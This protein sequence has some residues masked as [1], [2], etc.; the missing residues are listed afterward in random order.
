MVKYVI[1]RIAMVIPLL[2]FVTY[3]L[4]T[5][6]RHFPD[7]PVIQSLVNQGVDYVGNGGVIDQS[8]Y[9]AEEA[10]L[11][12]NRPTFYCSIQPSGFSPLIPSIAWHGADNQFHSWMINLLT[13]DFGVSALDGTDTGSKT[14]K[15][16][17]YT[18]AYVIPT[19][20]ITFLL[21]FVIGLGIGRRPDHWI[22]RMGATWM[23]AMASI[24]LFWI[25][26]MG[27]IYLTTPLYG[28]CLDLFPRVDV[29]VEGGIPMTYFV[30]PVIILTLQ[31]IAYISTQ[32]KN[33]YLDTSRSTYVSNIRARG[34]SSNT[35][36]K[37]HIV[38]NMMIPLSTIFSLAIP[39]AMTGSVV[40]EQIF[41]IPGIGRLL[42]HSIRQG[43]W[44][45]IVPIVLIIAL[46]T[47]LSYL[48]GD[49]LYATFDPRVKQQLSHE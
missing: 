30:L 19:L 9:R 47:T 15:A 4:Y 36:L 26:S 29:H 33:I 49:L 11:G 21:S 7:D 44:A 46:V 39:A 41:N 27:V 40:I 23:Y 37:K 48:L 20:L 18:L 5:L 31:S 35:I 16:F 38:P 43:D 32:V 45:V 1:R 8:V 34:L 28:K 24:P 3:A 22:S 14:W 17:G 6:T 13:L 42:L 2:I 12:L 25:A 10:R